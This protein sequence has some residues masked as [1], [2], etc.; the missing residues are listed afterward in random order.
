M[1]KRDCFKCGG[2]IDIKSNYIKLITMNKEKVIEECWFHLSCWGRYN[3]E[4]VEARV[5]E[6]LKLGAKLIQGYV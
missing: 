1:I 2:N 6:T 5:N 4:Q 3:Q